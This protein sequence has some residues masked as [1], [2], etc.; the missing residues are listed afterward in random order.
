MKFK[1]ESRTIDL[2]MPS[3]EE[4][5][6]AGAPSRGLNSREKAWALG[7]HQMLAAITA[8]LRTTRNRE[9]E[10]LTAPQS[11]DDPNNPNYYR[12]GGLQPIEV[13]RAWKLGFALGN[14]VKYIQRHQYK[15][16]L[17]D[18]KKARCYLDEAISQI[19]KEE[20]VPS[21]DSKG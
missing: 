19:E 4:L 21:E 2:E 11:D 10:L 6:K 13:I 18:L 14:C 17:E 20:D 16:G 15:N 9:Q 1:C 7:A 12:I 8:T 3:Q 5:V